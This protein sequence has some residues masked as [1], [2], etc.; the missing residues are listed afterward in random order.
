MRCFG[1]LQVGRQ[2]QL[3]GKRS[4][5]KSMSKTRFKRPKGWKAIPRTPEAV[6]GFKSKDSRQQRRARARASA[7]AQ[8]TEQFSGEPRKIRRSMAFARAKRKA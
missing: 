5:G 3:V 6:E 2:A 1:D 4:K 8:L 7:F